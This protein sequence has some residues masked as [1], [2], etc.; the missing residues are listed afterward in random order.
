MTEIQEAFEKHKKAKGYS[1]ERWND[2]WPQPDDE[3]RFYSSIVTESDFRL[4]R[5]GWIS[6]KV[7]EL[8]EHV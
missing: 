3:Q 7:D 2:N 6:A 8:E 5:A 4:F 1:L